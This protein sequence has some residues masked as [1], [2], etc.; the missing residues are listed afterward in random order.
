MSIDPNDGH[1]SALHGQRKV[2]RLS[3]NCGNAAYGSIIFVLSGARGM[4]SSK[5]VI[6]PV[7]FRH[8]TT[9]FFS[10]LSASL[11]VNSC[12]QD[13]DKTGHA[14]FIAKI[15]KPLSSHRPAQLVPTVLASTRGILAAT[16][17]VSHFSTL[18]DTNFIT[19]HPLPV[20]P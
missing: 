20:S 7:H 13:V 10:K 1:G 18:N 3:H 5:Q 15:A 9:P 12:T 14:V 19:W 17:H 8:F 4:H 11:S 6:H 16:L 2:G